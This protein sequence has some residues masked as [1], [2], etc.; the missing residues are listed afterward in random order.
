MTDEEDEGGT[1]PV[2]YLVG[3]LVVG[4]LAIPVVSALVALIV[5]VALTLVGQSLESKFETIATELSAPT[6][7]APD[8][9]DIEER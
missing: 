5:I 7:A 1:S 3:C 4:L 6:I 2:L 9:F 8:H